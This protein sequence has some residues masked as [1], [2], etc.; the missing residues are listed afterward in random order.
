MMIIFITLTSESPTGSGRSFPMQGAGNFTFTCIVIAANVK[1][2]ISAYRVAWPLLVF[3]I[4]SIAIYFGAFWF[5]TIYSAESDDFGIFVEL[6]SS[7]ETYMV[8]FFIMF[9]YVLID[10]GMRY[11]NIEVN[12]LMEKRKER[13]LVEIKIRQSSQKVSGITQR[14][15]KVLGK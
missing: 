8:A 4:G 1:L 2:L 11:G 3:V 5:M 13:A 6:F 12:A 9:S 14:I 15:T 10:S 7:F